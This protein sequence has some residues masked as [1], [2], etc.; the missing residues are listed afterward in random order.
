MIGRKIT[1]Q[2]LLSLCLGCDE[3]ESNI[4]IASDGTIVVKVGNKSFWL[5]SI[6]GVWSKPEE[7]TFTDG[8]HPMYQHNSS[9]SI[10]ISTIEQLKK[11]M[12]HRYY[13][14]SV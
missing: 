2:D 9:G 1:A 13:R 14:Y 4:Y 3:C 10:K 7:L 5:R 12:R 6:T 8:Y 11:A